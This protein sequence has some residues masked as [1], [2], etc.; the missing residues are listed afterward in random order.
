MKNWQEVRKNFNFTT[1]EEEEMKLE[2][3]IIQSTIE[4]RKKLNLTQNELSK[5][6]GIKQPNIAK[7]ENGTRS[8]QVYTL[9][10]ILLSMGYTLKVV[11]L[12]KHDEKKY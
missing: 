3:E 8:P 6:S 5:R 12:I 2:R 11:P 10:K 7:L 1:D 4:A 9:L